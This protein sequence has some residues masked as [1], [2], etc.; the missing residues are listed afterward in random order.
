VPI[1]KTSL[2]NLVF[3]DHVAKFPDAA[4][5]SR[6]N[7]EGGIGT[8][9]PAKEFINC[10]CEGLANAVTKATVL[11]I[12]V[13]TA[14]GG[15]AL[16]VPFTID[17]PVVQSYLTLFRS[18]V[19]V[20]KNSPGWTGPDALDASDTLVGSPVRNLAKVGFLQMN[21]P[22][23]MGNG[24]GTVSIVSNGL[25][26][27]PL[28]GA[29]TAS[30]TAAF[31]ASGYFNQDDDST[32]SGTVNPVVSAQIP[33]WASVWA[34]MVANIRATIAYAGSPSIIPAGGSNTGRFV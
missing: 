1:T 26:V 2:A 15:S 12:Y 23:G 18:T 33:T 10:L 34:G 25:M 6:S 21:P 7:S 19:P 11:D 24:S 29:L 8:H 13:G 22:P 28:T 32:K 4:T 3:A 16:P 14:G 20:W 9:N 31:A 30:L 27:A 17:E 5:S